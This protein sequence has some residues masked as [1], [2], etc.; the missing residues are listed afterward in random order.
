MSKLIFF[1]QI[2]KLRLKEI[3]NSKI[4]QDGIEPRFEPRIVDSR[5]RSGVC[6][7]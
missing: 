6:G 7:A 1:F 5:V 2:R 4:I 3:K